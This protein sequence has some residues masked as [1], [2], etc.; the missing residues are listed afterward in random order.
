MSTPSW[1]TTHATADARPIHVKGSKF[2]FLLIFNFPIRKTISSIFDFSF[3][4]ESMQYSRLLF[5]QQVTDVVQSTNILPD[6]LVNL[7]IRYQ[8]HEVQT[9]ARLMPTLPSVS[10]SCCCIYRDRHCIVSPFRIGRFLV[11]CLYY[12]GMALL[13]LLGTIL[14]GVLSSF[15]FLGTSLCCWSVNLVR[16]QFCSCNEPEEPEEEQPLLEER[17]VCLCGTRRC[18]SSHSTCNS[19]RLKCR[20]KECCFD[21]LQITDRMMNCLNIGFDPPAIG[22][23]L[24]SFSLR[25]QLTEVV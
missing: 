17:S 6:P 16:C 23:L 1:K 5:L 19:C 2:A 7:I 8:E 21:A 10:D 22:S 3:L 13:A 12:V 18:F 24:D 9:K 11:Y 4:K 20:C 25:P 15:L 14:W